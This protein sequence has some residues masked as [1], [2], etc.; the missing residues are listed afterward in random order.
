MS[1]HI[2]VCY[3]NLSGDVILSFPSINK[4]PI[5][6]PYPAKCQPL[7][8][9]SALSNPQENGRPLHGNLDF[10]SQYPGQITWDISCH[11]LPREIT[12]WNRGWFYWRH[13]AHK[14]DLVF[15]LIRVWMKWFLQNFAHVTTTMLSWHVQNLIVIWSWG[16]RLQAHEFSIKFEIGVLDQ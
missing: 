15:Y 5:E 14:W 1:H 16:I 13:F 4:K 2:S 10:C 6:V 9:L 12:L 8:K 11:Q 7:W 3:S